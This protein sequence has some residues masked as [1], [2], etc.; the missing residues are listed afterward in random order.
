MMNR[1]VKISGTTFRLLVLLF[2]TSPSLA[3]DI[4]TVRQLSAKLAMEAVTAALE[5]C[6]AEG[7][8]V[9]VAIVDRTGLVRATLRGDGSGPHTH[10]SAIRKA[11]TSATMGALTGELATRIQDPNLATLKDIPGV[12]FLAGGVP[13]RAGEELIGGIGVAG[14]PGGN[15]DEACGNA[16]IAAI[17]DRLE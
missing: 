13:I 5:S 17:Q 2:L 9:S 16:G 10:E 8:R 12:L 1:L 6:V 7:Y 15:F 14:A 3:Q 11:Y 4:T